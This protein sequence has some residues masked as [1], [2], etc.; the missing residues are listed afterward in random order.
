MIF[1]TTIFNKL[2]Q[3]HGI[4]FKVGD[5]HPITWKTVLNASKSNTHLWEL[6]IHHSQDLILSSVVYKTEYVRLWRHCLHGLPQTSLFYYQGWMHRW[7]HVTCV[8]SSLCSCERSTRSYTAFCNYMPWSMSP[9]PW[10]SPKQVLCCCQI[11][12][13]GMLWCEHSS[14]EKVNDF[15]TCILK[16]VKF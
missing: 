8:V 15:H 4:P 6:W 2:L 11:T 5:S 16:H 7:N 1:L 12:G 9:L 3:L 10:L 13:R 14:M